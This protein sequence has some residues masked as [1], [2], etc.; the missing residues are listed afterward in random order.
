MELQL[1]YKQT[2]VGVIPED[3]NE[4]ILHALAK[5]GKARQVTQRMMQELLTGRIRLV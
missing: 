4:A 1:G 3:W 2:E 5:R